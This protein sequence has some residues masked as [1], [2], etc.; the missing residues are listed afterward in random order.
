[1]EQK[2]LDLLKLK[3][4]KIINSSGIMYK[5]LASYRDMAFSLKKM[6]KEAE[7]YV[8][9]LIVLSLL[10]TN[11]LSI[12]ILKT[13]NEISINEFLFK[14]LKLKKLTTLDDKS[15]EFI[16]NKCNE[17]LNIAPLFIKVASFFDSI[18]SKLDDVEKISGCTIIE[19]CLLSILLY[20]RNIDDENQ[21]NRKYQKD[22]QIIYKYIER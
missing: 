13:L 10:K 17:A 20:I 8:Q 9:A 18:V 1:M 2:Y 7:D 21:I 12:D 3:Y 14:K 4:T 19:E 15:Y 22:I 6:S 5:T 11:E 16:K